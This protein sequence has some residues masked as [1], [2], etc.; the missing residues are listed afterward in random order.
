MKNL[1]LIAVL[2]LVVS[3]RKTYCPEPVAKL[4][5]SIWVNVS[6]T[7]QRVIFSD[8]TILFTVN[9][10]IYPYSTKGDTICISAVCVPMLFSVTSD[11]LTFT[12]ISDNVQTKYFK[13]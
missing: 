2:L 1:L 6:D 5:N 12:T 3:C 9:N 10:Q 8:R 13:Y 4:K 11:T 7:T